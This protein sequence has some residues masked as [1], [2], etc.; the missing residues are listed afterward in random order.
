MR[1][2]VV[3]VVLCLLTALTQ[4]QFGRRDLSFYTPEKE[5]DLIF[6]RE[7]EFARKM[8]HY[9]NTQR[10]VYELQGGYYERVTEVGRDDAGQ[11]FERKRLSSRW[12]GKGQ[13]G[14]F[15]LGD[16]VF[17]RQKRYSLIRLREEDGLRVFA[18]NPLSLAQG[19]RRFRGEIWVNERSENIHARGEWLPRWRDGEVSLVCTIVREKGL[20]KSVECDDWVNI[21][22]V[23]TRGVAHVEHFNFRRFGADSKVIEEGEP[24]DSEP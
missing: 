11:V 21:N 14:N 19:A 10:V 18:V 12:R 23:P 13:G 5:V 22:G 7:K 15:I 9:V 16:L 6:Q 4:A 2:I 8:T 20:P 24:G 1:R 3:P 17:R